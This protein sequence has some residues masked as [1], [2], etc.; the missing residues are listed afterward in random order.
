MELTARVKENI[1]KEALVEK[2]D[3]I[4]VSFSGGPDS[5]ALLY[6]LAELKNKMDYRLAA[7]Y[8]NHN[9]RPKYVGLEI[10]FCRRI[11]RELEIEFQVESCDVAVL[12]GERKLSIE[13][14]ARDFRREILVDMAKKQ[15][16]NKIALGHHQDDAIETILFRLFRGTGPGGLFPIKPRTG[17]F[18]RPFFNI[19]KDE[20]LAYLDKQKIDFMTDHTNEESDFSRNYIRN[21]II[22][23]IE[24]EFRDKYR[25]SL[26]NFAEIVHDQ[27]KYLRKHAGRKLQKI[28]E[29]TPG[30]KIVVDLERFASY[31][32]PLKQVMA[33]ILMEKTAGLE[34]Y[35][36]SDEIDNLI[37]LSEG[38][39]K[40]L[41]FSGGLR[42]A[43]DKDN[44]I[45]WKDKIE[46]SSRELPI[47]SQTVIYELNAMVRTSIKNKVPKRV[48][49]KKGAN[50]AC[51]S[52][53]KLKPPL[54][55]RAI[56]NGDR[57]TPFGMK[58]T[59]KVGDFLTDRKVSRYL[60]DEIPVIAD[61]N[62]IVWVVGIEIE[63]RLKITEKTRKVLEIDFSGRNRRN[64]R[65]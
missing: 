11:C 51:L 39:Y 24:K 8:L 36:T 37:K 21:E 29:I 42:A 60:R 65:I 19:A 13:T 18:I 47:P 56:A 14:A 53:D 41:D 55:L 5:T 30:K 61:Q 38:R 17:K 7:V 12:A 31:D 10:E 57:F 43:R 52:L 28:Q 15:K 63:D 22:P 35:G 54:I 48:K 2:G 3:K 58:G 34:G 46:L 40:A 62:G 4:L 26:L 9:L 32:L 20:I 33:K 45:L 23:V 1:V 44:I 25:R 49:T 6:I 27:D 50:R 16:F 64:E 59:K